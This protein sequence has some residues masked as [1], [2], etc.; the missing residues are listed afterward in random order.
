M[1][2]HAEKNTVKKYRNIPLCLAAGLLCLM[3]G[4]SYCL[5]GVMARYATTATSGGI[6]RVAKF[7]ITEKLTHGNS[8]IAELDAVPIAGG[9]ADQPIAFLNI[10]NNS[11]VAVEYIIT[12]Q[13]ESGN[14]PLTFSIDNIKSTAKDGT[15]TF[16]TELAPGTEYNY[17]LN[18]QWSQ[19]PGDLNA[20]EY[21]GMVDYISLTAE[22]VQID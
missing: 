22:A 13:N 12:V 7:L 5:S 18:S 6:G 14:L 8:L 21:M 15:F 1:K 4:S 11:E 9:E 16:T 10:T 2:H 19:A 17:T 20:L 3:L